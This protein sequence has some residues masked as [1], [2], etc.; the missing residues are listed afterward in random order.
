MCK[1]CSL[2][3]SNTNRK[4]RKL[5]VQVSITPRPV[6]HLIHTQCLDHFGVQRTVIVQVQQS[7]CMLQYFP[8]CT[9]EERQIYTRILAQENWFSA[10]SVFAQRH[11]CCEKNIRKKEDI[12]TKQ[13]Q[14]VRHQCVIFFC[15]SP[16][17][18]KYVFQYSSMFLYATLHLDWITK[19]MPVSPL[20]QSGRCASI[21]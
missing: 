8:L 15:V 20:N 13:R 19:W 7:V 5:N 14:P 1:F 17:C 6:G 4:T 16:F 9:S 18:G 3:V 11:I 10:Q 21:N 12:L 2:Y